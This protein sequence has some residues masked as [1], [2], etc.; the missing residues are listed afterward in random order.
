MR[1]YCE[2]E[3][4]PTYAIAEAAS[5]LRLSDGKVRRWA[6]ALTETVAP[7]TALSYVNLL[8][9]HTLKAMR[10]RHDVPLQRIRKALRFLHESL[11]SPHPLLD[12]NF[13]TNGLDLFFDHEGDL[14][15]ASAGGQV[16]LRAIV[17]R[18]LSRIEWSEDG[19]PKFYPFINSEKEDEPK[20]I[21]IEPG[22]AFGRPVLTGT[23]ISVEIIAGRFRARES[24]A[25]LAE[26]YGIPM[27]SVEDA[28]RWEIPSL[29]AA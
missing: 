13:A 4:T 23:G 14:V 6:Q 16:A 19:R 21:L 10:L 28:I 26:E 25:D 12:R 17:E 7:H 24:L 2:I 1:H 15:N 8:E 5:Y 22:L 20:S 3:E 11:P 29:H 9:L 27:S 18:Y